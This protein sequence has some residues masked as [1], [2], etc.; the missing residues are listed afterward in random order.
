MSRDTISLVQI[1]NRLVIHSEKDANSVVEIR[2]R[3][4]VIVISGIIAIY[5]KKQ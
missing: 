5:D 2:K 1:Q 3:Y 4:V